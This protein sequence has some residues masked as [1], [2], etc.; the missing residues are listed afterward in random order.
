MRS[1]AVSE[2]PKHA[3]KYRS[4]VGVYLLF[5]IHGQGQKADNHASNVTT[6][7]VQQASPLIVADGACTVAR[8]TSMD[9]VDYGAV[10]L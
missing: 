7:A 8:D 9:A 6:R 3:N 4:A 5:Q 1:N 2:I 10:R